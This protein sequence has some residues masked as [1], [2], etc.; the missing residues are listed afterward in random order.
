MALCL[1]SVSTLQASTYLR[2]EPR[3]APVSKQSKSPSSVPCEGKSIG[4]VRDR[5][6]FFRRADIPE[7]RLDTGIVS[8]FIH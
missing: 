1:T 2:K 4:E 5:V 7:C 6:D 8:N 3:N